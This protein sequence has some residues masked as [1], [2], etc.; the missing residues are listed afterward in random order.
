[1][2][3]KEAH[4]APDRYLRTAAQHA[5]RGM[6]VPVHGELATLARWARLVL[7]CAQEAERDVLK[8]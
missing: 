5:I 1:M 4:R 3:R 6:R 2:G 7:D 8:S